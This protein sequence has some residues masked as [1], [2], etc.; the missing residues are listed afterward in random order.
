MTA[1]ALPMAPRGSM[2]DHDDLVVSVNLF[3]GSEA[4]LRALKA[5]AVNCGMPVGADLVAWVR[6]RVATYQRTVAPAAVACAAYAAVLDGPDFH[7][8]SMEV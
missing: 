2:R 6:A 3:D 5:V 1:L 8:K 7:I 4:S